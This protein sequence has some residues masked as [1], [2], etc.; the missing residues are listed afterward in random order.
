MKRK[1]KIIKFKIYFI[2]ITKGG[3][4]TKGETIIIGSGQLAKSFENF[5]NKKVLIF[6]SGVSNSHCINPNEFKREKNLLVQMLNQHQDKKFVYFSSCALSALDYPKSD[7][8]KHKKEMEDI[9]KENSD[10][11]YIFRIPQLFGKLKDHKTLVNYLYKSIKNNEKFKVFSEAYRYVIEIYDV[12]LL[13]EEFLRYEES[14][15]TIDIANPYN[16]S[17]MELVN[18]IE[19]VVGQKANY[20]LVTKYDGYTLDFTNLTNFM[21]NYKLDLGFGEEYFRNKI[22]NCI[23][24]NIVKE[25]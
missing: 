1:Y 16:Y 3:K 8:Y 20:E 17:V 14:C 12:K 24:T 15:T 4:M 13:V 19:K 2:K 22:V 9:I 10:L 25:K 18:V 6:A 5:S 11:Y 23:D 21:Q 7:Y